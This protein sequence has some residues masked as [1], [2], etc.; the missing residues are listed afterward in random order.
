MI[1]DYAVWS[2]PPKVFILATYLFPIWPCLH[3][4]PDLPSNRYAEIAPQVQA[5]CAKHGVPFVQQ[6]VPARLRK[7]IDVMVGKTSMRVF[8][9]AYEHAPDLMTWRSD[10]AGSQ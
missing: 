9:R 10:G 6:S 3:L 5:L 8:P 7:T 2:A 1:Q 4:F